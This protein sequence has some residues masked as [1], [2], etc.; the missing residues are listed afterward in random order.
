MSDAIGR[1]RRNTIGD[2]LQR[3][4]AR[5]GARPALRF[6]GRDWSYAALHQAAGRVG[7]RL[8]ASGLAPGDRVVAYGRNSD[9]YLLL[10]L[11]CARAGLVHVPVNFAL[12]TAE[13]DYVLRQSGAAM[14]LYQPALAGPAEA[15]LALSPG[16]RGGTIDA[17][18]AGLD[19]LAAALDPSWDGDAPLGEAVGEEDLVQ[20]MYT[21]GTT[22]APKGAMMSH[23]GLLSE[24]ASCI[25]ELEMLRNDRG[26]AALPLYH[27]AQ[28]HAFTMPQLLNGAFTLLID[29]PQPALV[30]ELIESA[31]ITTFFAPPTVWIS[32][33]QHPDFA[34]RDLSSLEKV[35][36]GASIMP[37]PVLQ[38]LRARLP[39][40]RPF[41]CYG[42]TEIAPLATVLRPE[43]HAARPGSIGRAVMNVETR[44]VDAGMRDV[45]PGERGEVVHRSPQLLL[46][47]WRMPEET[48]KA[49]EGG[50]FHSGDVATIDAEGYLAIVDRTKDLINTGGVLVASREVEE[51]LFTH[52]EVAEVAVIA[53]PD[54]KWI[55]AVAAVVVL[56]GAAAPDIEALLLAHARER[57]AP[58]KLPKRIIIAEAL[59]KNTAGK[60]LK[61]ELRLLYAGTESGALGGG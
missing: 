24:Y 21:S 59:P 31:R 9:A 15:A 44:V 3:A 22:G 39:Q 5:F 33:L 16:V 49:F 2:A 1:A 8:L 20:I 29:A 58:Y 6:A 43:E 61:R 18:G 13:L 55:E 19:V 14:L 17:G 41:N 46:G 7:R 30:L 10:W 11:G 26:L 36:Y 28:M 32:L 40:A 4:A 42:Q 50:W 54:P 27:T 45:A 51:A 35:Q 48:A 38:E 25:V 23:R 60:L 34:T 52:P 37:V 57:L 56:R 53:V 47:Y 12:T